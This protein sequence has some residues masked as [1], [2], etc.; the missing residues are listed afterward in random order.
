MMLFTSTWTVTSSPSSSRTR[1]DSVPT[2]PSSDLPGCGWGTCW[3]TR[4]VAGAAAAVVVVPP[5]SMSTERWSRAGGGGGER[6]PVTGSSRTDATWRPCWDHCW[7]RRRHSDAAA[8][9]FSTSSQPHTNCLQ[10]NSTTQARPDPHGLFRGPGLRE[11][12]LGPCGSPT[13]SAR[14]RSGPCS[15]I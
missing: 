13:K 1:H 14:V 6:S 7:R 12:P 11:T 4:W 9:F 10:L 5:S 2:R 3:G 8:W 15:G